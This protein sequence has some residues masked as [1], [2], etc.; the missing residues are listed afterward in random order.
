M[1][2]LERRATGARL[3]SLTSALGAPRAGLTRRH[4]QLLVLVGTATLFEGYDRFITTLA[5]PHIGRDLGA[6]ESALGYGLA[7]IRIG[8]LVSIFLGGLADRYGRRRLLLLSIV[9]Y[10]F[11]TAATGLST[12]L[13]DFALFQSLTAIFAATEL[14]LAQ[15]VIAEEFPAGARGFGQGLLSAFGAVGCG[16]AAVLFPMLADTELG[17]RAMYFVGIVPLVTVAYFRR[18]L[19][20]TQLWSGAARSVEARPFRALLRA[21]GRR[22]LAVLTFVTAAAAA[23]AAPTFSFAAYRATN[24]FGWT[25]AHVSVMILVAGGIGFAGNF[26]SGRLADR[27]GR[28]WIGLVGLGGSALGAVAFYQTNWLFGAFA[29]MTFADASVVIAL[30]SFGTE[31]FPTHLRATAKVWITNTAALGSL[32]GLAAVGA[33]GAAGHD[34]TIAALALGVGALAPTV[35]LLPETRDR[36]LLG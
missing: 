13:T 30:N 33:F 28:R 32:I 36:P 29:L 26:V 20:E 7:V 18:N 19:P 35:L 5:L 21:E 3:A 12:G 10:T 27:L 1:I 22:Q 6:G 4:A 23:L 8:A 11:G 34:T 14:T 17:W 16:M 9:A 2:A 24:T 15:V 31:L 25:A